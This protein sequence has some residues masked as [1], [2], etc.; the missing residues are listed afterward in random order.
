MPVCADIA[1]NET[2]LNLPYALRRDAS[3]I[4][5]DE[6]HH[7]ECAVDLT[8]QIADATGEMPVFA[9]RPEFLNKLQAAEQRFEGKL[10]RL[11]M[12]TFTA[13]SETLITGTLTRVPQDPAVH[14]V[15]RQVLTDHAHDEARHHACFSDVI[16]IMWDQMSRQE[17]DKIGP[18]F[19]EFIEAFLAP[20][21]RAELAWLQAA[22]FDRS[23]ARRI[24]EETYEA[25]DLS[26]IYRDQAKP[27]I[28]MLRRYDVLENTA[29]LDAMAAR[30][31][32]L[33]QG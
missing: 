20:D 11:A 4:V 26:A 5:T 29:T 22:R 10:G 33:P 15:I 30:G 18:L 31:L 3:K 16:K 14:P 12:I 9:G 1:E 24:V 28:A 23:T 21:L 27:T 2:P 17:R 7:A 19:A 25:L 6:A 13:V 8:D 32:I